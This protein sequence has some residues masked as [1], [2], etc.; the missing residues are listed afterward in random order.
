LPPKT[1]VSA[2]TN[3]SSQQSDLTET[4]QHVFVTSKQTFQE[5]LATLQSVEN[6]QWHSCYWM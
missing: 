5:G 4:L 6:Y 3:T 2:V 1:F